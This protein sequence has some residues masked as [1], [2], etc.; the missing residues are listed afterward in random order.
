MF[1][2]QEPYSWIFLSVCVLN[3]RTMFYVLDSR[4]MFSIQIYN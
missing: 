2:I 3:S 4:T 1:L